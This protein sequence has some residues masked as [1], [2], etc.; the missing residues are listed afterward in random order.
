MS[1]GVIGRLDEKSKSKLADLEKE[2]ECYLGSPDGENR[3]VCIYACG[4]LG[5]LEATDKSD[6]DLF[7][8][9][10]NIAEIKELDYLDQEEFFGEIRRI[11]DKLH[12]PPPSRNGK[13]LKFIDKPN[14]LDIGS[15]E[16]DYNNGFTARML[17]ILE[18]K[19]IYNEKAYNT[20]IKEVIEKYFAD[21]PEH[22][23]EFYPL[24]LMN[25]ILRYWY[26]LTLNFEFRRKPNDDHNKKYWR[27]LKLKFSRK[28]T[29]Y[30][31]L[32]CL[33][34]PNISVDEV[35]YYVNLTPIERLKS[36]VNFCHEVKDIVQEIEKEYQW[37][38]GLRRDEDPSWWNC[39]KN[40]QE[41]FEH[42]DAF[43]DALIHKFMACVSKTNPDLK[44]KT[45][46]Y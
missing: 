45:D 32:A 44:S 6:L 14:L 22:Y 39:K 42:A 3:N 20:L 10:A 8:I 21:Y 19:P 24:F 27:R 33:Y 28:L 15:Q 17:L 18:S 46:M 37:F 12:Y 29:C 16:E 25:D 13:F 5:R 34:K 26:T 4:S 40:V 38:L 41:A 36:V 7:F 1:V 35:I 43:H 11:Q 30:S 9:C 23:D 2:I 31:M